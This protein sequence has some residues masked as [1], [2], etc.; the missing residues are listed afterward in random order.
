MLRELQFL[1]RSC[2]LNETSLSQGEKEG[3]A[4]GELH[5]MISRP[6]PQVA[7]VSEAGV[8]EGMN[9]DRSDMGCSATRILSHTCGAVGPPIM[10]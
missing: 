9:P 1:V 3:A 10:G 6:R 2:L 7:T 4:V 8:G 5:L